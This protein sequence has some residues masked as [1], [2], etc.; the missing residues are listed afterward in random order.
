MTKPKSMQSSKRL[1]KT[2]KKE[3]LRRKKSKN[4]YASVKA[5][6]SKEKK[7]ERQT[8]LLEREIQKETRRITGHNPTTYRKP[9]D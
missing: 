2:K 6:K 5:A 8:E 7:I 3:L 9:Q 1:K 4:K